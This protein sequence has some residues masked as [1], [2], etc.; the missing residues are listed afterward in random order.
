[1]AWSDLCG[2]NTVDGKAIDLQTLIGP[3]VDHNRRGKSGLPA[4]L[5]LGRMIA[6]ADGLKLKEGRGK[7]I[8]FTVAQ[9][10]AN[11]DDTVNAVEKFKDF[12]KNK[13]GAA[14]CFEDSILPL[15]FPDGHVLVH[16]SVAP[17]KRCRAGYRAWAQQRNSTIVVSSDEGYD[18]APDN[19]TFIFSPTGLV[20]Y[21]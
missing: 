4:A 15:N 10:T 7:G 5:I 12:V 8:S 21:G 17:C 11:P 14:V 16:Q 18:G 3:G 9:G 20:F 13:A 19:S 6:K 2:G 1:M